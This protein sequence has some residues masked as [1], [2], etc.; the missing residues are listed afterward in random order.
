MKVI[1]VMPNPYIAVDK[2]GV[3]QGV[4]G[5]GMPGSFVGAQLDLALTTKTGKNRFFFPLGKTGGKAKVHLTGDMAQAILAGEL[6]A[7]TKEDAAAVGILEK[8][9]L[10]PDKALAAEKKKAEAYYQSVKGKDA[11]VVDIPREPAASDEAPAAPSAAKQL[12]PTV[13][14]TKNTES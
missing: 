8:D 12:T 2:D 6:I 10:D 13:K 1:E 7:C 5:A 14:L 4:V 11:K 3:P 9:F